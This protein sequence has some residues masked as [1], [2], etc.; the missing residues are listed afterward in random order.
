MIASLYEDPRTFR[1][2]GGESFAEFEARLLGAL[3]RILA[4][5]ERGDV[6]VVAHGGVCRLVLGNL[7]GLE[8]SFWLR[9]AQDYGCVNI[10]EWC[11]GLPLI[12][13]VNCPVEA[14]I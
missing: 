8:P 14:L 2:P 7:L 12:K 9:L 3:R 13:R 11:R 4:E 1:Y 6:A 5:H 10:I